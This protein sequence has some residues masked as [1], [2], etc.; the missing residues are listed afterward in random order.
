M[1]TGTGPGSSSGNQIVT[2]GL[3]LNL[4]STLKY[5]NKRKRTLLPQNGKIT[6]EWRKKG[7]IRKNHQSAAK[8][9]ITWVRM[10]SIPHWAHEARARYKIIYHF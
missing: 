8:T 4:E 2:R 5:V 9:G 1:G 6:T 3:V 7:E 10:P